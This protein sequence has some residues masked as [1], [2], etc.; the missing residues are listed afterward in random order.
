MIEHTRATNS[1]AVR[2][3]VHVFVPE[4]SF[5]ENG[6]AGVNRLRPPG[7]R[8]PPRHLVVLYQLP[9]SIVEFDDAAMRTH[10]GPRATTSKRSRLQASRHR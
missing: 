7:F 10:R 9:T 1:F 8:W 6:T 5:I 2:A 3:V 4:E